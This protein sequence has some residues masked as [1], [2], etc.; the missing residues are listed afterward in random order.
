MAQLP[1]RVEALSSDRLR[2][3]QRLLGGSAAPSA[4]AEPV[5]GVVNP[6]KAECRQFYDD[7]SRS[8]D[9]SEFGPFSLFLNLGYVDTAGTASY[10][11]V[12]L[13]SQCLNRNSMRLVLE[14]IGD[15]DVSGRLLDVGCGRGG[16]V[17][18]ITH[19]FEPRSVCGLD[20]APAAIQFCRASQRDAKVAFH[21]GD[22]ETLPFPDASFDVVT[23]IESSSTYPDITAFYREVFRV[24]APAGTFLYTDALPVERFAECRRCLRQIGFRQEL[25]RD[26][27][28]NV[29]ASCDEIAGHRIQAYGAGRGDAMADFLSTP[30]SHCY[31][32]MKRGGWAYRIQRWT[33]PAALTG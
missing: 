6:H 16:T 25:D 17:S 11:V 12:T 33:K 21:V 27:T 5:P 24:L 26:I 18:V 14:V 31:D 4:C 23:N 2:L 20:L 3:L 8:L 30:G 28:E 19:F 32:E 7:L 22:A 13:P 1:K 10:S 15:C 9:A 29:L